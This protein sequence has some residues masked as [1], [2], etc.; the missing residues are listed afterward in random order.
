M[1]KTNIKKGKTEKCQIY[2]KKYEKYVK[3]FVP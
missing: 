2:E 3:T 1:K